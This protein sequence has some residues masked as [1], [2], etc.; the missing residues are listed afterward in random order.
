MKSKTQNPYLLKRTEKAYQKHNLVGNATL[1][2]PPQLFGKVMQHT[3]LF[4]N[5]RLL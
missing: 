3:F 5:A 2:Y 1:H 4:Q